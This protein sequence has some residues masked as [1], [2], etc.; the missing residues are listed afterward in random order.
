MQRLRAD[1]VQA[2]V[3]VA[4]PEPTLTTE[5]SGLLERVPCLVGP[6]PASLL[7]GPPGQG[8]ENA[9]EVRRDVEAEHLDVVA[10]VPDHRHTRRIDGVDE[11]AQE[12]RAAD[13]ARE[14]R[15]PRHLS[16]A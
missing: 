6:S 5:A 10:D 11:P 1:E 12:A 2:E 8:V 13:P 14:H 4:E 9:V 3:A 15:D 7:V 16:G